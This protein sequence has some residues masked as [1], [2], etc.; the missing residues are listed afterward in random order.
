MFEEEEKKGPNLLEIAAAAGIGYLGFRNRNKIF[1]GISKLKTKASVTLAKG[2]GNQT[3]RGVI[4]DAR[5]LN[6][7]MDD[8]IEYS[9]AGLLR[10]MKRPG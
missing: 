3:F 4:S 7:A 9:P 6:R 1:S 5:N 2:A 8:L 10:S